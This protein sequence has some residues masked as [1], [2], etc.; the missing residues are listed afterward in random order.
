MNRK[1]LAVRWTVGDVSSRGFHA[2][3]LSVRSM[4]NLLGPEATY[5]ISVN[6]VSLETL[7]DRLGDLASRVVWHQ[8]DGQ[9]PAW[10]RENY[11]DS[12]YA[13]GV[14]WKFA[15]V[16]L[17]PEIHELSLDNDVIFWDLPPS[18]QRWLATDDSCLIA[19]DVRA[20]FGVFTDSCPDA[21]RN[22]GIRGLPPG[23]DL[24]EALRQ[25]LATQPVR[26]TSELDEQ[27]LQT[28]VLTNGPHEVVTLDEITVCSP[29]PPHRPELGSCGAH[30]V[31][32]NAKKLPWEWKGKAGEQYIQEHWDSHL[33][34]VRARV[35]AA[36]KFS[37]DGYELPAD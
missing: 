23:F 27:G 16:R 22:T 13:E 32:L 25:K 15:P 7:Q 26:L 3:A 36:K 4:V 6:T 35:H 12:G 10:L 17:Y 29:I 2:L 30:F 31:G 34:T 18:V 14:A 33:S 21:G 1:P 37:F 8:A 5:V 9:T 19:E 28:A 11:L 20:A 24:E